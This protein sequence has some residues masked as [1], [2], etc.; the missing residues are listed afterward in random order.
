MLRLVATSKSYITLQLHGHKPYANMRGPVILVE[1]A[2]ACTETEMS[3]FWWNFHHWLH[4]KLS[5][6][7]LSV[8]PV[9]KI[10]S[11]WRHFRFSVHVCQWV[12]CGSVVPCSQFGIKPIPKPGGHKTLGV[13]VSTNAGII[14]HMHP[15]NE[16]RRYILTSSPIAYAHIHKMPTS[17]QLDNSIWYNS[18][19]IKRS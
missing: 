14:L 15:A 7:Q 11:K 10:S 13:H 1:S 6:W 16:R 17:F 5:K 8:P 12:I 19:S 4:R 9:T 2:D 3:S 18:P